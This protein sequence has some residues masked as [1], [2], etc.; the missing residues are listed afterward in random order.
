MI[1]IILKIR[2]HRHPA[3]PDFQDSGIVPHFPD[4]AVARVVGSD[5]QR[6]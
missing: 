4:S 3:P 2:R 1:I 5:H 6:A